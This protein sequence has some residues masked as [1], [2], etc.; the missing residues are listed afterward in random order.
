MK[1]HKNLIQ[2]LPWK[3]ITQGKKTSAVVDSDG[4]IVCGSLIC[5]QSDPEV[6][7]ATHA[8]IVK[9]VNAYSEFR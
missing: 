2:T 6:A 8:Y 4:F 9:A 5:Y 1:K 3:H 7:S